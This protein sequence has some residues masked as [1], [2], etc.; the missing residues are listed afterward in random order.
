MPATVLRSQGHQGL[1][2]KTIVIPNGDSAVVTFAARRNGAVDWLNGGVSWTIKEQVDGA[3][4]F[5]VE[6]EHSVVR[7]GDD[8]WVPDRNSPFDEPSQGNERNR[9]E[10]IRFT[11]TGDTARVSINSPSKFTVSV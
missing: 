8:D 3:D 10:R 9:I 5:E 6:V 7:D 11:N 4:D 1:D 2:V